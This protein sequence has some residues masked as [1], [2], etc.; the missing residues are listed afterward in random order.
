MRL[1]LAAALLLAPA[2]ALA[3]VDEACHAECTAKGYLK[4]F[5]DR[6]CAIDEATGKLPG[7][8]LKEPE[9]PRPLEPIVLRAE[10]EQLKA[11]VAALKGELET[12]KGAL[13][14]LRRTRK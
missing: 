7:S 9:A 14:E 1:A 3:R 6:G 8:Y 10:H 12:L 5:C 11:E 4:G 2:L 13:D